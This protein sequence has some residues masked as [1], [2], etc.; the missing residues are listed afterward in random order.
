MNFIFAIVP[1]T[2]YNILN[3]NCHI[4]INFLV[5]FQNRRVSFAFPLEEK[6]SIS[7]L[8]DPEKCNELALPLPTNE[9]NESSVV[10]VRGTPRRFTA[11]RKKVIQ[12]TPD[13]C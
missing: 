9:V 3:I 4:K 12:Y 8:M 6:R 13:N 11:V 1:N 2:S 5:H 10:S 7:D